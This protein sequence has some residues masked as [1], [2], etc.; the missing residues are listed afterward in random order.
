VTVLAPIGVV[1]VVIWLAN[2]YPSVE[3]VLRLG[4]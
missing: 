3:V 4:Q 1:G 2:Y